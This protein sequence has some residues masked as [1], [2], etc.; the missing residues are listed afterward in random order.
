MELVQFGW[1]G[2]LYY[3]NKQN[4]PEGNERLEKFL[5]IVHTTGSDICY[6]ILPLQPKKGDITVLYQYNMLNLTEKELLEPK[7]KYDTNQ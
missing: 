5:R 7:E 6:Y 1:Y 3:C 2:I 4:L